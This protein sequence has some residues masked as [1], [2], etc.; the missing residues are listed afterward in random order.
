MP[1]GMDR[2][3]LYYQWNYFPV[4][5]EGSENAM[6]KQ[7]KTINSDHSDGSFCASNSMDPAIVLDNE[8]E[9]S[10]SDRGGGKE[11]PAAGDNADGLACP[12]GNKSISPSLEEYETASEFRDY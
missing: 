1:T 10:S 12:Y 2:E 9:D 11:E 3:L 6:W 8:H 4:D 5:C 7:K